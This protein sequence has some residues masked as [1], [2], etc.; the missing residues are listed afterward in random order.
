MRRRNRQL[1]GQGSQQLCLNP[2]VR[3]CFHGR[4]ELEYQVTGRIDRPRADRVPGQAIRANAQKPAQPLDTGP[5][6]GPILADRREIFLSPHWRQD[7]HEA[8]TWAAAAVPGNRISASQADDLAA[9]ATFA[10]LEDAF[11]PLE[12]LATELAT[13]V[14]REL[15]LQYDTARGK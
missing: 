6:C 4:E 9:F 1:P 14:D 13:D 2:M 11:E 7:T 5:E 15:Q 8:R 3:P 12:A 10:D